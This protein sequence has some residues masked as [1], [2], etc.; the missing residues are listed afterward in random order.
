MTKIETMPQQSQRRI[1][2]IMAMVPLLLISPPL[3]A[4]KLLPVKVGVQF[5]YHNF[6]LKIKLYRLPKE[7]AFDVSDTKDVPLN[8]ALPFKEEITGD[9]QMPQRRLMPYAIAIENRSN[10]PVFFYANFHNMN[11]P[12]NSLGVKLLCLCNSHIYQI[13]ANTVWYRII[14]LYFSPGFT[15]SAIQ[16]SHEIFGLTP[17]EIKARNLL[18]DIDVPG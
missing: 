9:F 10:K 16:I 17:E 2:Y 14:Q 13:K 18:K 7:A 5:Q 8:S 15:G 12:E 11:P 4:E 3:R 6:P 1:I